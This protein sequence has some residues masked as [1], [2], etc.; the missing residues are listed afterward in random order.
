M[1]RP[2]V[3]EVDFHDLMRILKS[4]RDAR[5]V[6][7]KSDKE[8]WKKHVVENNIRDVSL[9][10]HGKVKFANGKPTLVAIVMDSDWDGCYAYSQ[11][12]ESAIK[13]IP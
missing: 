9:E 10:A 7:E 2:R 12:D 6:I 5:C 3:E 13:Y 4:A 8:S 11:A 1:N